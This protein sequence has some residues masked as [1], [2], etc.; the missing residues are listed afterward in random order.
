MK[1][2]AINSEVHIASLQHSPTIRVL[3]RVVEMLCD[4]DHYASPQAHHVDN[5]R[6]LQ[7]ICMHGDWEMLQIGA[8]LA[9]LLGYMDAK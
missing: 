4:N 8:L 3:I 2:E 6:W 1:T 7:S 5:V 9:A